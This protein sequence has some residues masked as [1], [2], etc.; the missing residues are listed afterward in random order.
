MGGGRTCSLK[1]QKLREINVDDILIKLCTG[2]FTEVVIS[3]L[4]LKNPTKNTILYKVKT[5][6]PKQYCVRPNS[7]ILNAGEE[8]PVSGK[9]TFVL[10]IC[11]GV[12]CSFVVHSFNPPFSHSDVATY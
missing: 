5:T 6:A 11:E 3:S 4:K 1:Q 2:P 9:S 7:G 12:Y 8:A 10:H